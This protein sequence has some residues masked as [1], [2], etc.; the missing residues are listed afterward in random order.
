MIGT[1]IGLV[2]LCIVLGV[3]W[4]AIQQ[5]LPLIPLG[6]PFAT[7]LRVLLV[8]IMVII[9]LWV[10]IQLLGMAGIHVNTFGFGGR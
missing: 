1:L 3:I 8:L 9:V 6:Q 10:I 4:W 2:F 7:I 5:F